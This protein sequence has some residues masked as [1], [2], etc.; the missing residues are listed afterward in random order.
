M[1]RHFAMNMPRR[2]SPHI[3]FS[4][5]V[6]TSALLLA[7]PTLA[8]RRHFYV[9]AAAT[10]NGDGSRHRPFWRIT[11]AVVRARA[12]REEE[13]HHEEGIVIHVRPGTYVGSY[14]PAHLADNPRL[15]LL[16]IIINVPDLS[17][18]GGTELDED[19]DGLPTGTYPLEGETLLITDQP[20]TRGRVLLLIAKTDDGMAGNGVTVSGFVMDARGNELPTVPGFNIY[21]DRVSDFSIHENFFRHGGV[22]TRLAS[23]S[24]E[25]NFC[26][27]SHLGPGIF[28]SGGSITHPARVNLRRNRATQ[29]DLGGAGIFAVANFV[30]LDLGANTLRLET[31]QM[32]YDIDNPED[33]Q[34]I[35]DTLEATVENNDLSDNLAGPDGGSGYGLACRYYP[36]FRYTTA[37]PTQAMRGTLSVAVRG[38]RLNRNANYGLI[39]DPGSSDRSTPRELTGM[40]QGAFEQNALIGN[41]RNTAMFA[42]TNSLGI[43]GNFKYM[44]H[45]T[46]QVAD[47]DGGLE[48]FDYDHPLNDPFDGSPVVGN[49]IIY[50]GT[51]QPNGIQITTPH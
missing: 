1:R 8:E 6:L 13:S 45:S 43:R 9:D 29:N 25:A 3:T 21:A 24:I 44:Q 20:L 4:L 15:E 42:F 10:Q 19:E 46:Y 48:G 40:F 11:N 5:L 34:N 30:Q 7:R 31:L 33:Q 22:A 39:V 41:G 35:P 28:I 49:V 51:L 18:E 50:N 16:P 23:G 2:I 17:L 26:I 37:D 38:N 47:L 14:D 12:L 36:P 27:S 32:S